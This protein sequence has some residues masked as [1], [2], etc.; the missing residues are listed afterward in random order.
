MLLYIPNLNMEENMIEEKNKKKGFF[1]KILE[2]LDKK[3]KGK[4]NRPG[5]CCGGTCDTKN[6]EDDTKQC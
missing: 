3:M 2:S 5:C 1:A 4:A 6:D